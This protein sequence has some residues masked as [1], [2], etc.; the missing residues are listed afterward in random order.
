MLFVIFICYN[1]VKAIGLDVGHSAVKLAYSRGALPETALI[2]TA[3]VPAFTIY[4]DGAAKRAA[5]ETVLVGGRSY[6]VGETAI[7]QGGMRTTPGL[8]ED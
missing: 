3:V 5:R 7:A 2:P 6:F 4:D 8:F 1:N